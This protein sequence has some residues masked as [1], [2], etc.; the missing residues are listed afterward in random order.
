MQR[1]FFVARTALAAKSARTSPI[2]LHL[3]SASCQRW[4]VFQRT[5]A[6]L[7]VE[8]LERAATPWMASEFLFAQME[9]T[10]ACGRLLMKEDMKE[11]RQ[12][13]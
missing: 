10:A 1:Q 13:S 7:Y 4:E 9:G 2:A 11:Y 12:Q 5:I 3:A 8:L 6:A